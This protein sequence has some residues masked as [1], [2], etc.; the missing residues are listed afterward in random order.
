MKTK[1][2]RMSRE[3]KRELYKEYKKQGGLLTLADWRRENVNVLVSSVYS[4]V[5]AENENMI[6]SISPSADIEKCRNT[7]YADVEK[8]CRE[9]GFVDFIIPQI[10]Y[11]FQNE[12]MPFE[13]VFQEWDDLCENPNIK[14]ICGLAPYKCGREDEFAGAGKNEWNENVNILSQQ[15]ERVLESYMWQGFSLFSYSYCFGDNV[16]EFSKKEIKK[17]LYMVE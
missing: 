8:W 9:E 14:L 11:G 4:L 6:F 13:K 17:L 7:F 15:Y 2:E 3:E 12:N 5:K 10:Y 1:Y 16:T